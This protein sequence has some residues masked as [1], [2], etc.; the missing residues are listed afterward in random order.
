MSGKLDRNAPRGFLV[1][2]RPETD[3]APGDLELTGD[4]FQL[5]GLGQEAMKGPF[6]AL[7]RD[8]TF[9]RTEGG[10]LAAMH[11]AQAARISGLL[12]N[13][14]EIFQCRPSILAVAS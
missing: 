11:L 4:E 3:S 14:D 12:I 10:S 1:N 6:P 2:D 5:A 9:F 13:V 7:E 8:S